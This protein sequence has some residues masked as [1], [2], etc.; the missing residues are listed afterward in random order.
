MKIKQIK[1][2]AFK[3]YLFNEDGTFNFV[4]NSKENDEIVPADLISLYAPNGFG[5]TSFYDAIDY[6]VTNNIGRYIRDGLD[7]Q[8]KGQG[9]LYNQKGKKQYILRNRDADF[10]EKKN[11]IQLETKIEIESTSR[12]FVSKYRK[13]KNNN[14]DYVFDPN[15]TNPDSEYFTAVLLSQEA[16]DAFLREINPHDRFNKFIDRNS[17]YTSDNK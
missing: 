5:K 16:I 7:K 12:D 1:I 4:M 11:K 17:K 8:N 6:A 14:M 15:K 13:P 3:S 10:V 2:Q 9:S